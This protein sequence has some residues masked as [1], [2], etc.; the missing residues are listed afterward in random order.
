MSDRLDAELVQE[1]E[2]K[3]PMCCSKCEVKV[4]ETLHKLDG[5]PATITS[6]LQDFCNVL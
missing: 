6:A 2:L 3:V 4:K 1:I 5:K